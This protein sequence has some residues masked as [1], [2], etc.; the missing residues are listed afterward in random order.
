VNYRWTFHRQKCCP[1]S[2]AGPTRATH[3]VGG[4]PR[5]RGVAREHARFSTTPDRPSPSPR[6]SPPPRDTPGTTRGAVCT[7]VQ[8]TAARMT[9][10]AQTESAA[11]PPALADVDGALPKLASPRRPR[12][13]RRRAVSNATAPTRGTRASSRSTSEGARRRF[14]HPKN[15]HPT[16]RPRTRTAPTRFVDFTADTTRASAS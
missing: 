8:R 11:S 9:A 2:L 3:P 4:Y 12:P 14:V 5:P 15:P 16:Q 13:G 6:S 1:I 10:P 7:T